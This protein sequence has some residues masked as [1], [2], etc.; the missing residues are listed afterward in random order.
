MNYRVI[1]AGSRSFTDYD[2]LCR[3]LDRLLAAR[4]PDVTIISGGARGADSL[5]EQYAVARGL[6]VVVYPADWKTHGRAA[7]PIRN[8]IMAQNADALAAFWDGESK[9]T[10]DMVSRARQHGLPV[11]VIRFNAS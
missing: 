6:T 1:V 4:M 3:T 2:L 8:E 9:G 7:G 11:R 10:A 5:A